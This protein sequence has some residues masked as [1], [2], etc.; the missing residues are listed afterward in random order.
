MSYL[1]TL[2][3]GIYPYIALAIFVIGS[4][5][6]YD[7]EQYTWKTGSSQLLESKQLKKGSRAFHVGIIMVLMGHFVGLLTPA[8]LWHIVGIEASHKQLIAMGLGGVFG[9]ICFYGLTILIKRRLYNPRVRATSSTMDIAILLLLYVQLI[10]GLLSIFVSAGHM[11]GAEM[12]KLMSW[13]QNMVT[14]DGTE[15]A[16]AIADVHWIYKLHVFLGMTLFVVFPFSRLVHVA[17]VPI[18]YLSRSYQVVRSK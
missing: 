13:A 7:R 16:A 12:L 18:Q 2:M 11:D 15:A 3:F 4:I 8:E 1:N 9:V 10:L 17:S 5:I 14:F 6:R